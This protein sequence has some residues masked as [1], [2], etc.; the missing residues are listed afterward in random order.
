MKKSIFAAAIIAV[1]MSMAHASDFGVDAGVNVTG[2]TGTGGGYASSATN[3]GSMAQGNVNGTGV[4]AQFSSNDG[5][6]YAGAGAAV[7]ADGV[8]TYTTGGSHASNVSAGFTA[9]QAGGTTAGAVGTDFAS[10]AWGNFATAGFG[11]TISVGFGSFGGNGNN[12]NNGNGGHNHGWGDHSAGNG[13]GH[14]NGNH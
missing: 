11:G 7:G 14:N 3:G 8:L 13:N 4:S 9:G 6:G 5:G 2:Y 1:S 10:E 12:G